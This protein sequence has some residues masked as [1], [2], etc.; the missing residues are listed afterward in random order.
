MADNEDNDG[1]DVCA[2]LQIIPN[3]TAT[4]KPNDMIVASVFSCGAF[5]SIEVA[6]S[7]WRRYRDRL[8]SQ[9]VCVVL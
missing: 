9:G 2:R 4:R 3:T 8:K 1:R 6:F 7:V 5:R